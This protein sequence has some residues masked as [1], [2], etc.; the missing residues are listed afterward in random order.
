MTTDTVLD[1]EL[2]RIQCGSETVNDEEN[3]VVNGGLNDSVVGGRVSVNYTYS[4]H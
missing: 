4:Q 3:V 1:V 2:D